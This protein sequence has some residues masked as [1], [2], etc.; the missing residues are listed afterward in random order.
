[1]EFGSL[2]KTHSNKIQENL[3]FIHM[4]YSNLKQARDNIVCAMPDIQFYKI[5]SGYHTLS[6]GLRQD[7]FYFNVGYALSEIQFTVCFATDSLDT[8]MLMPFTK[9][10]TLIT[11]P[12]GIPLKLFVTLHETEKMKHFFRMYSWQLFCHGFNEKRDVGL[13][14]KRFGTMIQATH[15]ILKMI[16]GCIIYNISIYEYET[17]IG[18][19]QDNYHFEVAYPTKPVQ[20]T[21]SFQSKSWKILKLVP[22]V[23]INGEKVQLRNHHGCIIK[24]F[25]K[26]NELTL[27]HFSHFF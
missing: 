14:K 23:N 6:S 1:M 10:K 19:K 8:L 26:V 18:E 3:N 15:A 17:S 11:N 9:Q 5:S 24:A 2:Y 13:M 12:Q 25:A 21:V 7:N 27:Q 22:F 4:R 16:P 20:I